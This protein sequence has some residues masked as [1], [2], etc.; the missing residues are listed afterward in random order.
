MRQGKLSLR[1]DLYKNVFPKKRPPLAFYP[2]KQL[3]LDLQR[4][5]RHPIYSLP[6]NRVQPPSFQVNVG[7]K[8]VFLGEHYPIRD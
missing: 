4:G 1:L 7:Q 3:C 2:R 8:A 6:D 5:L